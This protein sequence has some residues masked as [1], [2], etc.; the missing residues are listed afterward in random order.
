MKYLLTIYASE[1][2]ENAMPAAE[3]GQ[4]MQAYGAYTEA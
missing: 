2:E 4:L 3:L 1:A